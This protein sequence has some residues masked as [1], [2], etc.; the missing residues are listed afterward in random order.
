MKADAATSPL[1]ELCKKLRLSINSSPPFFTEEGFKTGEKW[2][3][4][5]F[6]IQIVRAQPTGASKVIYSGPFRMGIGCIDFNGKRPHAATVTTSGN[7]LTETEMNILR[8]YQKS[9][10]V[11]IKPEYAKHKASLI[12]KM[13]AHQRISPD[14]ATVMHSLI[15]DGEAGFD[16][17]TF[18]QWADSLGYDSD[19]RSAEAT[20]HAC[21]NIGTALAREFTADEIADL[22]EAASEF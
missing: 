12:Q 19:S 20:Y 5:L 6:T 17:L 11:N 4:L 1:R 3:N 13:A 18:E 9:A 15:S 16:A 10:G 22:R 8:H 2:D 7:G 14:L 21:R